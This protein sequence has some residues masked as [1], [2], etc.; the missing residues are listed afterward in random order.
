MRYLYRIL[1]HMIF[2]D[3]NSCQQICLEL[4]SSKTYRDLYY[5]TVTRIRTGYYRA[6]A[7]L[8]QSIIFTH[9]DYLIKLMTVP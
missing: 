5:E 1:V 6:A 4:I 2:T 3:V 9:N 8:Y 7:M